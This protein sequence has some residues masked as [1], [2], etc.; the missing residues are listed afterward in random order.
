[1]V[2]V[3]FTLLG[4]SNWTGGHHY[5]LN[6]LRILGTEFN[7]RITPVLFVAEESGEDATVAFDSIAGIEIVRT[8]LLNAG[9]SRYSLLQALVWGRDVALVRLFEARCI[10]LVFE[11]AQFFGWRLGL[12]AIAWIPDFQHL[13]LPQMFS[14]G[15]RWRR[16]VGFRAQIL[17]QRRIMLSS[18]DARQICL[19]HY[20][21]HERQTR[22]VHFAVPSGTELT[23][24]EA[25]A[26][27][28]EYHLP[29]S[30][31]YMPNQMWRHKNHALVVEA[32][33]LLK[34]R[35]VPVVIAASG[36]Q[37]D[38]RDPE[39]FSRLQAMVES[40]G[41][42]DN[43]RFLGLI[44]YPHLAALMRASSALLNPSL[45]EGWSTTVEEARAMGVPML[46]SDLDV[47]REQ[48]GD[49]ASYFDRNSAD[50]LADALE[51]FQ[52]PDEARRE[53]MIEQARIAASRRVSSF[54]EDFTRLAEDCVS[55]HSV[56]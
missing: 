24:D 26:V 22:T 27:A 31:F 12:P 14:T 10:N 21:L 51:H 33:G 54:G 36:R 32:L 49:Q 7:D 52:D 40:L 15:A 29:Q 46:L 41:I 47:H 3:A 50:S 19:A 4:G 25:R 48:M 53:A 18:E 1:M 11:A 42:N 39:V 9:R 45:S 20:G 17:G 55:K 37:Q 16:E 44:P 35:G 8:S 13:S 38:P 34:Q 56:R 43:F 23:L 2:R 30:F 5:L 6:L 28:A